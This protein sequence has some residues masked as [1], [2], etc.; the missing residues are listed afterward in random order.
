MFEII[1]MLLNGTPEYVPEIKGLSMMEAQPIKTLE[2]LKE[3][4]F[5][6][7]HIPVRHLPRK[8]IENGY[9]IV[10]V[11][12]NPK[13]VM[14]SFFNHQKIDRSTSTSEFPGTWEDYVKDTCLNIH[15][16]IIPSIYHNS[17]A[18]NNT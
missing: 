5:M 10:H 13:D 18:D 8:H 11:I 6:N 7:T 16:K 2:A 4:R 12:R 1:N 14:V 3:P 9:K 15:S 17:V